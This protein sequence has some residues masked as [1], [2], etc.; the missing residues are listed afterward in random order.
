MSDIVPAEVPNHWLV[1]FAVAS[2]EDALALVTELGG[3]VHTPGL[4]AEGVGRFAVVAD[5]PGVTFCII[6]LESASG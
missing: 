6:E 3:T 5:D 4:S 1:Y 2:S